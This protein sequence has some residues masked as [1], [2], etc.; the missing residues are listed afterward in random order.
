MSFVPDLKSIVTKYDLVLYAHL[1]VLYGQLEV[2]LHPLEVCVHLRLLHSLV[3][4][5][6]DEIDLAV[7]PLE[8]LY[9]TSLATKPKV[10]KMIDRIIGS[11][12]SVPIADQCFIVFQDVL[13]WSVA[14]TQNIRMAK[15]RIG[16][17]P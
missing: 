8:D 7:E 5:A 6:L 4:V 11:D 3:M 10:A 2:I 1:W 17:E 9:H 12:D 14:V 13:E 16:R 15:V